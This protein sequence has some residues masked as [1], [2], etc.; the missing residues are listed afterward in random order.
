MTTA[1]AATKNINVPVVKTPVAWYKP[2]WLRGEECW[3]VEGF[4]NDGHDLYTTKKYKGE[5]EGKE[6]AAEDFV[7]WAKKNGYEAKESRR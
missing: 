4:S 3:Q 5:F 6:K 2:V 7:R 1:K